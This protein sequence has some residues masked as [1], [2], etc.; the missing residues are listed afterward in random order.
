M[1]CDIFVDWISKYPELLPNI[2]YLPCLPY[3]DSYLFLYN[4]FQLITMLV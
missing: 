3:H 2:A 4:A 1:E